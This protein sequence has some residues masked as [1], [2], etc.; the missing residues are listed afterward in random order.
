MRVLDLFSGIGGFSLGL[1]WAGT[2]TV[3]FVEKDPYCQKI[4]R[5]H[6]PDTPIYKDIYDDITENCDII[7]GGFP[8]QPFSQAGKQKGEADDRYLWPKM[9]EI[10]AQKRPAF[11]IGENVAGIIGMAL[12][13]VLFDLESEGYAT[14]TFII[15]AAGVNAPHRRDR[16]WILAYTNQGN[17][18][19]GMCEQSER[20]ES[21]CICQGTT[22]NSSSECKRGLPER[23]T[24]EIAKLRSSGENEYD[25]DSQGGDVKE[26]DSE[27]VERQK[28]EPREGDCGERGDWSTESRIC[29]VASGVSNRMDRIKG[30]GNAVV[31]QIVS[32]IG[33][34]ILT[35]Y[36]LK[37]LNHVHSQ[38]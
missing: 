30:L 27:P 17:R 9:L 21:N 38:H 37:E 14:R 4:L 28:P 35:E 19:Q 3:A 12:D 36:V 24:K 10:I 6:W 2:H 33:K 8:C 29:G 23:E 22:S 11:V 18:R 34:I 32:E 5:K 31:P 20:T 26:C 25:T 16:V 1:E 13:Q 15:P 7:T